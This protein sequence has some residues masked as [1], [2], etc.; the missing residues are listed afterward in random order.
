MINLFKSKNQNNSCKLFIT[1]KFSFETITQVIKDHLVTKNTHSN[2]FNYSINELILD[3]D[4]KTHKDNITSSRIRFFKNKNVLQIL[5]EEI[6]L[7]TES[8]KETIT[9]SKYKLKK[10]FVF[11]AILNHL[12]LSQ[13]DNLYALNNVE[14]I[15]FVQDTNPFVKN[16]IFHLLQKEEYVLSILNISSIKFNKIIDLPETNTYYFI[17]TNQRTFIVGNTDDDFS[18]LYINDA[19]S[20]EEKTGKDLVKCQSFS[21]YTE[22]MNDSYFVTLLPIINTKK[23]RL[24]SFTD[25]LLKTHSKTKHLNL[26]SQCY[27]LAANKEQNI[28]INALKSDL[29]LHLKD[30]V[31]NKKVIE[32]IFSVLKKHSLNTNSF[33]EHLIKIMTDW[34]LDYKQQKGFYKILLRLQETT[35]IKN[36]IPFH[37]HFSNLFVSTE[38]K[39]EDIFE[40]NLTLGKIYATAEKYTDAIK[41]YE[42]IHETLP[43]DSITDLLP[44]NKTNLLKG[45]GGQQLEIT[46]LESILHWKEKV[47]IN[48][49]SS[50]LKLAQ[51]QPLLPLRIKALKKHKKHQEKAL[52][53][54]T[55]LSSKHYNSPNTIPYEEILY[56]KLKK[57]EILDNV[58]PHCFKNAT[59]FFDSLN[60]FIAT[61]KQPDYDAVISFSDKLTSINYPNIYKDITNICYALNID[62]PECYIGRANYANTVIGVEGKPPYLIVGVNFINTSSPNALNYNELKFLI[63]IELAHIYFEH[64]KITSTDVWRGAAEKGF[65]IVSAVLTLLPFA[66]SLGNILGNFSNI[67]RYSKILN[68]V[69]KATNV[70]EKGQNI[71]EAGE[72]LNISLLP[73]NEND[74]NKNQELLITSRLMEIIADKVALLFSNDIEAA[75]KTIVMSLPSY[76]KELPIIKKYGLYNFLER[77]DDNGEFI[78]QETIIRI[79]SLCSFYLSNTFEILKEKLYP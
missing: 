10:H 15:E 26:A 55:V 67:E 33:G 7:D 73:K 22:L 31:I 65:S 60:S 76:E 66:G 63:A 59:G 47:N 14:R 20:I 16:Y 32:P 71:L 27:A 45:Q 78:Y 75:I 58:V 46:I 39:A 49:S 19:I 42:L 54:E 29:I 17:V 61:I 28:S 40:F 24:S 77:V 48:V 36:S 79:R 53:I 41:T 34:N 56:K 51:L 1:E 64:S 21:F 43:D 3:F 30:L 2:K 18:H 44:T 70:V 37:T 4:I 72:K 35:A 9:P 8:Y 25:C 57:T 12:L 74:K 23:N 50:I 38:K 5:A 62:I 11:K 52:A 6:I 13:N 68:N 69:E